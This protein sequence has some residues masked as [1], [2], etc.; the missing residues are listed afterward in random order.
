MQISNKDFQSLNCSLKAKP[1][2]SYQNQKAK[3]GRN[4]IADNIHSL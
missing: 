4:I 3:A 2:G 1:A